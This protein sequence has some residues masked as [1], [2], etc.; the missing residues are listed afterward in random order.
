MRNHW[1]TKALVAWMSSGALAATAWAGDAHGN[2]KR[3][4]QVIFDAGA[5]ERLEIDDLAELE[6]GESRSY[7]T[8]SGKTAI[9]TRDESGY[10][11]DLDGRKVRIGD[12]LERA[13]HE[14]G[15]PGTKLRMKRIELDG[16]GDAKSFVIADGPEHGVY[17]V[18][19]K[20]GE[21]GF[22]FDSRVGPPPPFLIDGLVARL[23]KN[24]KFRSLDD[25]T[26]ELVRAAIRESAPELSWV[27]VD[28]P[29]GE[30]AMKIIVRERVTQE[31]DGTEE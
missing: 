20:H 10:E 4:M 25:A 2:E 17:F 12:E 1:G 21:H 14:P 24:E 29:G 23:E 6:V 31:D 30:G 26:Q 18:D 7:T 13:A 22:A 8:E 19:G 27:G 11:V 3:Q 5:G 28:H 15:E 16:D 9:V